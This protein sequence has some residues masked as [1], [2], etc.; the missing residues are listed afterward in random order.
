MIAVLRGHGIQA[1]PQRI[2]V[3]R[4]VLPTKAHPSAD[5]VWK[6]VRR[7]CPT[8]SRAT[9][10]NALN[11]FARKGLIRP[12]VLKGGLVVFDPRTDAHHHFIDEETGRIHDVPWNA[13]RVTGE[14]SLRGYEVREYQVVLR[15]R[16]RRNV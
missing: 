8:L 7:R 10:Y 2:A 9:V 6:H 5:E 13:I 14:K 15:G 12:Q 16:R 4:F 11:L 1:T 3:A